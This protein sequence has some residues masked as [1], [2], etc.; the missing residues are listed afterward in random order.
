MTTQM[1]T[2]GPMMWEANL[3]YTRMRADS[4]EEATMMERRWKSLGY[5]RMPD[6]EFNSIIEMLSSQDPES[7][8]LATKI[9]LNNSEYQSDWIN[10]HQTI[11]GNILADR[12]GDLQINLAKAIAKIVKNEL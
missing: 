5:V 4:F 9:L 8:M 6:D 3:G 10:I 7:H 2:I 12:N 11:Q 1:N